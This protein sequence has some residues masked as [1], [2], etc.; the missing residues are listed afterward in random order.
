MFYKITQRPEALAVRLSNKNPDKTFYPKWRVVG[1]DLQRQVAIHGN[2]PEKTMGLY[3]Q[4]GTIYRIHDE[5]TVLRKQNHSGEL[6]GIPC[7]VLLIGELKFYIPKQCVR[8][9]LDAEIEKMTC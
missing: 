1:Q 2:L 5:E 8:V 9:M 4:D 6:L 7:V 3:L